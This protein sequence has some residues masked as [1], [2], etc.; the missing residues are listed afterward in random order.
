MGN[1]VGNG[2]GNGDGVGNGVGELVT[3]RWVPPASPD[4]THPTT[5]AIN[6]SIAKH[7]KQQLA[8]AIF[9]YYRI[10]IIKYMTYKNTSYLNY[11]Y[12]II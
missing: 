12:S 5:S 6:A 1:S 4:N 10:E 7:T 3:L 8:S 9:F 11:L 2:V